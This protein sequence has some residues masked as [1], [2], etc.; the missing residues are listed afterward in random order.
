MKNITFILAAIVLLTVAVISNLPAKFDPAQETQ[1]SNFPKKIGDWDGQDL[2]MRESDYAILETRNLIM[3]NYK[4]LTRGDVI[5]LY[6]IYSSDNCKA[7]HPPEICYTGG[8]AGTIL[9][10]G[11]TTLNTSFKANKFIIENKASSQLVI[12]W[13]KSGNLSTYS[14]LHQQLKSVRDRLM[15][16][17]TSGA[18]IRISTTIDP[19]S[20]N[21][22]MN[23]IKSFSESIIPVINQY[24]P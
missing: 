9:E 14:Y 24:V 1:M 21:K 18:M 6:I 4:N 3:R 13:F 11:V 12:Y 22:A 2:K 17:K 20:P 19:N 10:K 8:G 15:Q 16:K 7:L 23:L 5:T